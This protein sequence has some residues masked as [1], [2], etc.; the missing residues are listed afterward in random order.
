MLRPWV[1]NKKGQRVGY[2]MVELWVNRVRYKMNVHRI[3]LETFSGPRPDGYECR[4]LNG[5]SFDNRLEN[6]KWG[7]PQENADDRVKHNPG[8]YLTPEETAYILDHG[9]SCRATAEIL[10]C[11]KSTISVV[12]KKALRVRGQNGVGPSPRG[13]ASGG[14]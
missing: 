13:H 5:D 1:K 7:K 3:I 12:R 10:G 4:H 14:W 8:R 6:L 11:G 2:H 9:F